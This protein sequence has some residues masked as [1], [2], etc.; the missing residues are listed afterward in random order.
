MQGVADQSRS[1]SAAVADFLRPH[2]TTPLTLT[3]V[4]TCF[5]AD[6]DTVDTLLAGCDIALVAVDAEGPRYP[7]R[8]RSAR[9]RQMPVVYA[10]VYGGGAGGVEVI[11]SD[12]DPGHALLSGCPTPLLVCW[13]TAAWCWSRP[14]SPAYAAAKRLRPAGNWAVA[15]LTSIQPKIAAVLATR[16]TLAY[17]ARTRGSEQPWRELCAG[18]ATA[19]RLA[20]RYVPAWKS[21]PWT[22]E[23]IRVPR[24]PDCPVCGTGRRELPEL[25]DLFAKERS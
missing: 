24:L 23:P 16:V 6:P 11:V 25:T 10:G 4:D 1:K 9:E 14:T 15:D 20:L 22:L 18:G 13:D 3:A 2:F 21:G 17:L 12:A 19:W 8:W 7:G 5:L